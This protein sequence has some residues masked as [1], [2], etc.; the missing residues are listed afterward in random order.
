MRLA[1]FQCRLEGF[2]IHE[3]DHK[4][5][6]GLGIQYHGAQQTAI[7]VFGI[8]G[9]R[10]FALI[11]VGHA[12]GPFRLVKM[13]RACC[14]IT[15]NA[16]QNR[17]AFKMVVPSLACMVNIL[18]VDRDDPPNRSI[19]AARVPGSWGFRIRCRVEGF[20]GASDN[21]EGWTEVSAGG[22][23][24]RRKTGPVLFVTWRPGSQGPGRF[25]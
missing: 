6:F 2:G 15:T 14:T 8:E 23:H 9:A 1:A 22:Q 18:L 10:G 13:R 4:D 24:R 3:G 19:G 7:I 11:A 17:A 12:A 16:C 20:R 5:V 21:D 25:D